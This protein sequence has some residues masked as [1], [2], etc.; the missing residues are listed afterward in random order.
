VAVFLVVIIAHYRSENF[1]TEQL[2]DFIVS[3]SLRYSPNCLAL[4][5]EEGVHPNLID[6]QKLETL[7]LASCF[8]RE[9]FSYR[10]SLK[11]ITGEEIKKVSLLP[12]NIEQW[13]PVCKSIRTLACSQKDAY[14][15]YKDAEGKNVPGV[16][17]L[18]VVRNVA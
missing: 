3:T 12:V 16:L 5:D 14:V 18:E 2:E 10:V 8:K 4:E 9:D 1:Q 11:A 15:L 7:K 17:S 13:M 6:M